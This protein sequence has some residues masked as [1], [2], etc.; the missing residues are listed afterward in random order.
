MKLRQ[1]PTFILN[2]F[3]KQY[4]ERRKSFFLNAMLIIN[5]IEVGPLTFNKQ[6]ELKEMIVIDRVHVISSTRCHFSLND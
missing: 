5:L 1:H 2:S 6:K 4:V 3:Q